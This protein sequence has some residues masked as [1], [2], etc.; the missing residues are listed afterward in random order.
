MTT[1]WKLTFDCSD[2]RALAH[3]WKLALG[4]VDSPPPQGHDTWE[5][6]LRHWEVP[7]EEW[8]DGAF[9]QDPDGVL[10]GISFLRV[11]EPKIAKNRLH[12]DV[13]AA[14]SRDT[15]DP[16]TRIPLI[17]AHVEQ[18]VAAGGSVI[19]ENQLHGHL[20]GVVMADPEGNEF[21][22]V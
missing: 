2:A 3:F 7:E 14:G 5:D 1:P 15:L 12:I 17:R 11:P 9:I 21:C 8:G 19:R 10:P 13:Y 4:Y 6:W 22:V 16:E 18:L 20:D